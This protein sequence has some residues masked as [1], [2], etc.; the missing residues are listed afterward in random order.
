MD[1]RAGI[2]IRS[3]HV[4]ITINPRRHEFKTTASTSSSAAW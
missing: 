4:H 1:A 3:D 2:L